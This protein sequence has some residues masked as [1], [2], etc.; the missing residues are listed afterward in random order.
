MGY[1]P[2][3]KSSIDAGMGLVFRLNTLFNRAEDAS[4][5]GD[6]DK[7]NFILDRIFINLSYKGQMNVKF[8]NENSE[9][10]PTEVVSIDLSPEEKLI[11][12]KFREMIK[13]VKKKIFFSIKK[14]NRQLHELCK[15]EHYRVL[16]I[17]DIW[18][19]KIMMERGLYLKEYDFNPAQALWGG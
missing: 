14:R 19:R 1:I 6:F 5:S 9:Q 12:N 8:K 16:M 10:F 13:N 2:S 4:M 15:D 3:P 18:L 17:K 7:W 11:F